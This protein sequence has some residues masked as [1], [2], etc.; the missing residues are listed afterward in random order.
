M[1]GP[2]HETLYGSIDSDEGS[3][4]AALNRALVG[5]IAGCALRARLVKHLA[6]FS[7]EDKPYAAILDDLVEPQSLRPTIQEN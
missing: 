6:S 5:M 7:V 1:E 3:A 2:T 4:A